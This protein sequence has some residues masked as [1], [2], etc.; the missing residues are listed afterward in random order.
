MGFPRDYLQGFAKTPSLS[1]IGNSLDVNTVAHILRGIPNTQ[2]LWVPPQARERITIHNTGGTA[3]P[4]QSPDDAGSVFRQDPDMLRAVQRKIVEQ[5]PF[6][7]GDPEEQV[8]QYMHELPPWAESAKRWAYHTPTMGPRPWG[9]PSELT[10]EDVRRMWSASHEDVTPFWAEAKSPLRGT[11]YTMGGARRHTKPSFLSAE[12][13]VP[14]RVRSEDESWLSAVFGPDSPS[15]GPRRDL[16]A[17][18]PTY[19]DAEEMFLSGAADQEDLHTY[20]D[21][22]RSGSGPTRGASTIPNMLAEQAI[23][24]VRNPFKNTAALGATSALESL[25]QDAMRTGKLDPGKALQS[26]A[27]GT[28]MGMLWRSPEMLASKAPALAKLAGAMPAVGGA[29]QGWGNVDP[30]TQ[31]FLGR[32]A[33]TG[34]KGLGAL[35]MALG[36][37]VPGGAAAEAGGALGSIPMNLLAEWAYS[38][39]DDVLSDQVKARMRKPVARADMAKKWGVP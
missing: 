25:A 10:E 13:Q 23:D 4:P 22:Y 18:M 38:R 32:N 5:G 12:A 1:M 24:T 36:A 31:Q 7:E 33:S 27:E 9:A 28:A 35:L 34:E 39:P 29:L 16:Y 2:D 26:G 3:M 37:L 20:L 15:R 21:K 11:Y 6:A 30:L 14:P 17:Q 8:L 19:A